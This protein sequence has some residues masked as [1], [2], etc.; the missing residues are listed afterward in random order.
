MKIQKKITFYLLSFILLYAVLEFFLF[1]I[2]SVKYK[3]NLSPTEYLDL[4]SNHN[5]RKNYVQNCNETATSYLNTLGPHPYLGYTMW[6]SGNLN[7]AK[8]GN[9]ENFSGPD[10]PKFKD[11]KLFTI[12]LTGG[13]VADQLGN[14]RNK[15]GGFFTEDYLNK[16]FDSGGGRKFKLIVAALGDY[17]LPQNLIAIMLYH[18]LIDGVIDLSGYNESHNYFNNSKLEDPSPNY[19]GL[20]D[21]EI[22]NEISQKRNDL[23]TLV[24]AADRDFFCARSYTC[25]ALLQL[26]VNR[27]MQQLTV[28]NSSHTARYAPQKLQ[29]QYAADIPVEKMAAHRKKKH[30]SYIRLLNGMCTT[31]KINCSFFIQPIPQIGKNKVAEEEISIRGERSNLSEVY[32]DLSA[33]LMTLKSEKVDIYNL[34]QIFAAEKGRIYA[35]HIHYYSFPEETVSKG[36]QMIW[37]EIT[38]K[39][40]VSWKLKRKHF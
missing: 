23:Y 3:K 6:N 39:I 8:F 36:N 25:M 21:L 30:R 14:A 34:G 11:E 27:K 29:A 33:N 35:D 4:L 9:N 12:L 37:K 13:S 7:C 22:E 20:F 31:L 1:A 38:E 19:W 18:D 28:Q 10:F 16:H 15:D 40:A 24:K 26:Y 5:W 2:I 32:A 17:R